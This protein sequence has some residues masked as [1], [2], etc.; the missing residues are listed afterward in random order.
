MSI[1]KEE[2]GKWS[3]NR[4]MGILYMVVLLG[5]FCYKEAKDLIIQ[6]PEIFI[7]MIVTAASLLGIKSIMGNF[8]KSSITPPPGTPPKGNEPDN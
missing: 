6:S 8:K 2:S 1:F 7:G 5:L 3:S 4:A